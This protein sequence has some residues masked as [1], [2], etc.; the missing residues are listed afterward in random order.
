MN[1]EQDLITR[2]RQLLRE[3]LQGAAE[4]AAA[5]ETV[6]QRHYDGI[7]RADEAFALG[8]K[9]A[10]S[11]LQ[12]HIDAAKQAH[13]GDHESAGKRLDCELAAA[14]SEFR[15]ARDALLQLHEARQ[16]TARNALHDGRWTASALLEAAKTSAEEEFREKAKRIGEKQTKLENM[17]NQARQLLLDWKQPSDFLDWKS[18]DTPEAATGMAPGKLPQCLAEAE[19][20]LGQLHDL[21]LPRYLRIRRFAVIFIA[22]WLLFL[23][24]MGWITLLILKQPID[25]TRLA[26]AGVPAGAGA[27]V[28]VGVIAYFILARAAANQVRRVA[29]PLGVSLHGA[30]ARIE[31]L[32]KA[33]TKRHDDRIRV[34]QHRSERKAR[35]AQKVHRKERLDIQHERKKQFNIIKARFRIRRDRATR[36]KEQDKKRADEI[37]AGRLAEVQENFAAE[38]AR[39]ERERDDNH[40]AANSRRDR[41][42]SDYRETWRELLCDWHAVQEVTR[43]AS[44]SLYPTWDNFQVSP[45][46]SALK[47]PPMLR[48]GGLTLDQTNIPHAMPGDS[49]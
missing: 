17:R 12:A 40:A 19:S 21:I 43:L 32:T 39:L 20:L 35:K 29:Q 24:P 3:L 34:A 47:N 49:E 5:E 36:Q 37:H 2:Q 9:N 16:A 23:A 38:S 14:G 30:A 22:F 42:A 27:A 28:I 18:F 31:L 41:E 7:A 48:F 13:T 1:D 8:H 26:I 44:D 45:W 33:F 46:Q 10:E 11:Q 15:S 6:A 4:R 25:T